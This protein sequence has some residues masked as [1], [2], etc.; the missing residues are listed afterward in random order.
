[1][2]RTVGGREWV[3]NGWT[4]VLKVL[5][6]QDVTVSLSH[7]R[8]RSTGGDSNYTTVETLSSDSP[9]LTETGLTEDQA[10]MELQELREKG[11]V[12]YVQPFEDWEFVVYRLTADG[13]AIAQDLERTE[14]EDRWQAQNR[15][16]NV[17]LTVAT[18][19]LAATALVQA[20]MSLLN[21]PAPTNLYLG[22][23]YVAVL[24]LTVALLFTHRTPGPVVW[25]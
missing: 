11:L 2:E 7:I 8:E 4:R 6:Q 19:F 12:D 17:V 18:G 9:L 10:I 15:Q 13:L 20:V 5:S 3:Q 23:L 14:R 22:G 16:I 1:M 24:G 21:V 25:E